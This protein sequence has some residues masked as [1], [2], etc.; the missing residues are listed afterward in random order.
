MVVG[1]AQAWTPGFGGR[2]CET[3]FPPIP[4]GEGVPPSAPNSRGKPCCEWGWGGSRGCEFGGYRCETS[5]PPHF[6]GALVCHK[7]LGEFGGHGAAAS[8]LLRVRALA[9]KLM[10]EQEMWGIA[11]GKHRS[12]WGAGL[13]FSGERSPQRRFF[14][15]GQ[16]PGGKN[17]LTG[18]WGMERT[19][20]E[21][22]KQ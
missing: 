12:F 16:E 13:V 11:P 2:W 22:G 1:G 19:E 15:S 14:I 6:G 9:G 5:P 7:L 10:V 3:S 20:G 4:F 21:E 8:V 18:R 17:L